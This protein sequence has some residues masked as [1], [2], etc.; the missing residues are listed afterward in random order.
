MMSK[1]YKFSDFILDKKTIAVYH[2]NIQIQISS[3]AFE[4]LYFLIERRGEV[5]EKDEILERVWKDSFVEEANLPVHISA[6]RR[7]LQEKKGESR[8]I[9]TISGRGYS[10]IANVEEVNSTQIYQPSVKPEVI[11]KENISIAVLPFTFESTAEDN[12]YLANGITQ[13]L[14]NDLSQIQNLRVLA[15]SAVK[16]YKNSELEL[17]EI[18][19]LLDSDK[20]LT[21]S[22]SEYKGKLEIVAELINASDKSCLWGTS[23]VFEADDIFKVKKEISLTITEKLKLKLGDNKSLQTKEIDSEAQKL[24]YR[25]KFILES[26]TTRKE[27]HEVLSQALKFFNEAV[28]IE[29]N[30]ALAYTGIGSTFV[31]LHNHNLIERKEAYIEAKK[32]LQKA[33]NTDAELSESFVLKGSIAVMFEANF[34]EAINALDKAIELNPNNPDA[35]HWKSLVNMFLGKFDESLF[36]EE[37]AVRLDPTSGRFNESLT[38]IFCFSGNYK[39]AIIQADEILEF[40]RQ[41]LASNFFNAISYAELGFL[42]SALDYIEKAVQIRTAPDIILAKAY[43]YVLLKQKK[44]AVEILDNVLLNY[45]LIEIDNTD[46]AMVYSA[47]NEIDRAFEYLQAAFEKK[48]VGMV[49]LKID[50]RFKKLRNDPRFVTLL[51]KMNLK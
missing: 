12:E 3:R 24:Y 23:Q 51:K 8:Y 30:Y 13:S 17:Q 48:S 34:T 26:R 2:N 39:K 47:M 31:S 18:G 15:Y 4:I 36:L 27:P 42:D 19:F 25:G 41:S 43:I 32:A 5:V 7:V 10:F 50:V 45:P 49:T 1:A 11:E 46:I 22:I 35:Y 37:K 9:R 20:I 14:I 40:D 29:P 33:L 44:M 6:I 21:G 38:R 28:R 16:P